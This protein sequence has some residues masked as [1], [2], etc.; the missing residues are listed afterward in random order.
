M[1][2]SFIAHLQERENGRVLHIL[3][4]DLMEKGLSK[5]S[6]QIARF[7]LLLLFG[8]INQKDSGVITND[9]QI[10]ILV[11]LRCDLVRRGDSL[12]RVG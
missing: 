9:H 12:L 11:L 7:L 8:R 10:T 2:P 3:R 4:C 1:S 6:R 5:F